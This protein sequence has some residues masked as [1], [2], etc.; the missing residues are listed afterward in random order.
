M[1]YRFGDFQF[2]DEQLRLTGPEGPIEL[3]RMTLRVLQVLIERA[4]AVVGK[5]AL[6]D[7]VWGHQA[8]SA[9]SL[10]QTIRELRAALGDDSESPR[11]IATR[12]RQGYQFV[13]TRT[14]ESG[15]DAC[16]TAVV[17][18]E[19]NPDSTAQ[20]PG[21]TTAASGR[22][23]SGVL[24]AFAIAA[25][26]AL[27]LYAIS[28]NRPTTSGPT[29]QRVAAAPVAVRLL[30][31]DAAGLDAAVSERLRG[32]LLLRLEA[33]GV[34]V[35]AE[36]NP[37]DTAATLTLRMRDSG[38]AGVRVAMQLHRVADGRELASRDD[39][40]VPDQF[41]ALSER[42]AYSIARTLQVEVNADTH[43]AEDRGIPPKGPARDLFLDART[44]MKQ[45][46]IIE[47]RRLLRESRRIDDSAP[48]PHF[49]YARVALALGDVA[50]AR[51]AIVAAAQ[52]TPQTAHRKQLMIEATRRDIEY[53]PGRALP[54]Y[55]ALAD[56]NEDDGN[57]L[58]LCFDAAV[59]A[60]DWPL[61]VAMLERAR[62]K[63]A[64]SPLQ[65][66][67]SEADLAEARGEDARQLAAMRRAAALLATSPNYCCPDSVELA[68]AR[69]ERRNG[70]SAAAATRLARVLDA[71]A[72]APDAR[73][74]AQALLERARWHRDLGN[75]DAMARDLVGAQTGFAEI[76][77]RRGETDAL[78]D[79][80]DDALAHDDPAL[81]ST[82]YRTLESLAE[83]LG[84]P[85]RL[86]LARVGSARALRALG[87]EAAAR[88]R[89]DAALALA[90]QRG[91]PR[92]IETASASD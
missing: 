72:K 3:R 20:P 35:R 46:R 85:D 5:D 12:H 62:T 57:S 82:L 70:Q 6:I 39:A 21:P 17:P 74:H 54:V 73:L 59:A 92:L 76:G 48:N 7:A 80:A 55:R 24:A 52:A 91:N 30:P 34:A 26:I 90:R 64:L 86:V 56:V 38:A 58:S 36:A 40:A 50:D 77:D 47:A 84:D 68:L 87:Q 88:E 8:L 10:P 2:D 71:A 31:I 1:R 4:P 67:L 42:L 28:S 51:A 83:E 66:A 37:D 53:G 41:A 89:R 49:L 63:Q 22:R 79:R 69:A 27:G 45:G 33:A 61:A 11:Y 23:R 25:S 43:A 44:A 16:V 81:A 15:C 65:L 13:A 19:P 29:T 60:G 75:V 32:L 18:D 9:S 78:T 14:V